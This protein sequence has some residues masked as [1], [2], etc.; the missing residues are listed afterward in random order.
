MALSGSERLSCSL[1]LSRKVRQWVLVSHR[2]KSACPGLTG[3][4]PIRL[5]KQELSLPLSSLLAEKAA[6]SYIS[7]T[8]GPP[9][10]GPQAGGSRG[11]RG[12]CR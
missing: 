9:K 6:P 2:G 7:P 8:P 4:P 12:G 10:P 11:Q 3:Q 1:S 5:S